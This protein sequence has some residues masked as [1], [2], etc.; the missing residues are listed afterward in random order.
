MAT[1]AS[2]LAALLEDAAL[3]AELVKAGL[4]TPAK[5]KAAKVADLEKAV[6][7]SKSDRV[8]VRFGKK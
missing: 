4:D 1:N 5:I 7:R 8:R 6:G 2:K 3:A